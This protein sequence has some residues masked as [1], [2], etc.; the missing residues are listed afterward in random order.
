MFTE[1]DSYL[2]H[3][4]TLYDAYEK[5][6]AH[7]CEENG[8]R[9]VRFTVW[10]QKAKSVK[11]SIFDAYQ[12]EK[13]V[14]LAKT[15]QGIWEVFVPDV[16]Q[17]TC[18]KYRI[19]GADGKE[20][21]KADPWAFYSELRPANGSVVWGLNDYPWTD[22]DYMHNLRHKFDGTD[23]SSVRLED[24]PE[25]ISRMVTEIQNREADAVYENSMN[26]AKWYAS[27]KIDAKIKEWEKNC[28]KDK[29]VYILPEGMSLPED[30]KVIAEPEEGKT[31]AAAG[32]NR[33][34]S[35]EI[36]VQVT[37]ELEDQIKEFWTAEV[38]KAVMIFPVKKRKHILT[39]PVQNLPG[40]N[41]CPYMKCIWDPGRRIT[42]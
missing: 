32:I 40:K 36:K 10:A 15:Q 20:S 33:A 12:G 31:E 23:F 42:G 35:N 17:G 13:I 18:Y 37:P 3:E 14:P 39:V 21:L 5:M 25:E 6:G 11:V 4:G 22:A 7:I 41:P 27:E 24:L 2:F 16:Q 8:C 9:G 30:A 19:E 38:E 29:N 34:K 26:D 28:K 1:F